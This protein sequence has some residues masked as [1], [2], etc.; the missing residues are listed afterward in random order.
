MRQQE[1]DLS[2]ESALHAEMAN[3]LRNQAQEL[4]DK[5]KEMRERNETMSGSN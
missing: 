2:K 1:Q 3:N 5:Y 4:Q